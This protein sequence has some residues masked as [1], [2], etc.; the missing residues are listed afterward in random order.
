MNDKQTVMCNKHLWRSAMYW[1]GEMLMSRPSKDRNLYAR[2]RVII[3]T[4]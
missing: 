2:L 4:A 3:G 1:S